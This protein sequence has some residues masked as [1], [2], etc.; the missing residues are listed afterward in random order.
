MKL[1]RIRALLRRV[2]NERFLIFNTSGILTSFQVG[3]TLV[4]AWSSFGKLEA[5]IM[6]MQTRTFTARSSGLAGPSGYQPYRMSATT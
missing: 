1:G 4:C 6:A 5:A 2:C 3:S